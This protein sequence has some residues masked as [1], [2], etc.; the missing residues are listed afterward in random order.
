MKPTRVY[1]VVLLCAVL[2][3]CGSPKPP[4]T[5]QIEAAIASAFKKDNPEAKVMLTDV[6]IE[7]DG[8]IYTIKFSC[9]NCVLEG[10]Q[11][12]K[13]VVPSTEGDAVVALDLQDKTWKI[14]FTSVKNAGGEKT[15]ISSLDGYKF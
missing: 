14:I 15:R 9:T 6:R 10:G 12:V 13:D 4:S 8:K 7:D 11:G 2:V 1:F 5:E 3:G